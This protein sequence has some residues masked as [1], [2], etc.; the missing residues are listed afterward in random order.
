M[1]ACHAYQRHA[2]TCA[3][4]QRLPRQAMFSGYTARLYGVP[5]PPPIPVPQVRAP[6]P[7]PMPTAADGHGGGAGR[8]KEAT[9]IGRVMAGHGHGHRVGRSRGHSARGHT[10][11]PAPGYTVTT[12]GDDG[13]PSYLRAT[14][15]SNEWKRDRSTVKG[16]ASGGSAP[17]HAVPWGSRRGHPG[18]GRK[19]LASPTRSVRGA[20]AASATPPST[21][22]R[23]PATASPVAN[24]LSP[25]AA[26]LGGAGATPLPPFAA[27]AQFSATPLAAATPGDA[28]QGTTHNV[29]SPSH[30]GG[31]AGSSGRRRDRR[32]HRQGAEAQASRQR[33]GASRSPSSGRR[34]A[35]PGRS[36]DVRVGSGTGTGTSS[37]ARQ[38]RSMVETMAVV[39]E[40][41]SQLT[42]AEAAT[43]RQQTVMRD[44]LRVL[45]DRMQ[46]LAPLLALLIQHVSRSSPA[47]CVPTPCVC[48]FCVCVLVCVL[49]CAL[50]C[51]RAGSGTLADFALLPT[52]R[53]SVQRA[54]AKHGGRL[55]WR[56][57]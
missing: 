49:V 52:Q 37:Q 43:V 15:A 32:Q 36:P 26:M 38:Y 50:V 4:P 24:S 29:S 27:F 40:R 8:G 42:V 46:L 57:A 54:S 14:A 41:L 56:P 17:L 20:A 6:S 21:A 31:Q 28:A 23:S 11:T 53:S 25:G 12:G 34:G 10:N 5:P 45:E 2:N 33:R 3:C 7:P 18:N 1:W 16:A 48:T 13:T 47:P 51:V 55:V 9:V 22:H 19:P 30:R 39:Q 35:S 44:E